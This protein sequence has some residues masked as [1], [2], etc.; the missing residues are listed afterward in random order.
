LCILEYKVIFTCSVNDLDKL[1]AKRVYTFSGLTGTNITLDNIETIF[2][3]FPDTN[4]APAYYW[5]IL[6]VSYQVT[7]GGD[8]Q[9]NESELGLRS[10][11]TQT[12]KQ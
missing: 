3:N 6:D 4:I 10:M 8:L 1:I 7:N 2:S 5:Y 9:I 12:V 11:S